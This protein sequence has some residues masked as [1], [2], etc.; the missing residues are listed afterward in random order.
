MFRAKIYITLKEGVLDPQGQAV[1]AGLHSLGYTG[2]ADVRMA[3][4]VEMMVEAN[5]AEGA[6]A[7]V[8]E[9]CERVLANP[10]MEEYSFVLEALA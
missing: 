8:R 7:L 10:V 1:R 9:M 3:K 5:S 2:V 6:E 4:S